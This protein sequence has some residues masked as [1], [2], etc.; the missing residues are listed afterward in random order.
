MVEEQ[1]KGHDS[2]VA[3]LRKE[4]VDLLAARDQVISSKSEELD[5]LQEQLRQKDSIIATKDSKLSSMDVER[6]DA[7]DQLE[8]R[9][10]KALHSAVTEKEDE[11]GKLKSKLNAVNK[12]LNYEKL[13]P[14]Q[15]KV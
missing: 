4:V 8:K 9:L 12:E 1:K 7:L 3:D 14:E 5:L 2:L 6:T 11:I 15:R 10:T 13:T